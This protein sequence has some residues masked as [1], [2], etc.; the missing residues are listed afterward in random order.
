MAT[1]DTK[2]LEVVHFGEREAHLGMSLDMLSRQV[3]SL[4]LEVDDLKGR[5][6]IFGEGHCG[7]EQDMGQISKAG[8]NP[9]SSP[10]KKPNPKL[11]PSSEAAT[12]LDRLRKQIE[13]VRQQVELFKGRVKL[14]EEYHGRARREAP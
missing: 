11:H 5:I 14:S 7:L 10:P 8:G 3:E 9:M 6:R 12:L 4:R 1:M 13:S 2:I